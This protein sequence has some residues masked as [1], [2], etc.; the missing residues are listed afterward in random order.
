MIYFEKNAQTFT[1]I[2][3]QKKKNLQHRCASRKKAEQKLHNK[4]TN[5][6][7]RRASAL[8]PIFI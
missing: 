4:F 3:N 5:P 1:Q 8:L 7:T 2:I 6:P